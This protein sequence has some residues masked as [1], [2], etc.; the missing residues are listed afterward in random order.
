MLQSLSRCGETSSSQITKRRETCT[1]LLCPG[2]DGT[3]KT[4]QWTPYTEILPLIFTAYT[5]HLRALRVTV[6]WINPRSANGR[7]LREIRLESA[8][9]VRR[10]PGGI[11]YRARWRP[12][13]Q[14]AKARQTLPPKALL[15]DVVRRTKDPEKK[16]QV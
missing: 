13:F 5:R 1:S 4:G 6:G 7:N 15:P 14:V 10:S 2:H 16:R 11:Q 9:P 8:G 3:L 12:P